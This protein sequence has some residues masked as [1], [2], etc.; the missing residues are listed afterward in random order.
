MKMNPLLES[1]L[2]P[3]IPPYVAT[4]NI[5]PSPSGRPDFFF[6]PMTPELKAEADAIYEAEFAKA[7]DAGAALFEECLIADT[8]DASVFRTLCVTREWIEDE[9]KETNLDAE[10]RASRVALDLE[11]R[12][13]QED[14]LAS[15]PFSTCAESVA[16]KISFAY[17][18]SKT[19]L[20][21][22]RKP[23]FKDADDYIYHENTEIGGVVAR[24][25]AEI[26][27]DQSSTKKPS[28]PL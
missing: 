4:A 13:E 15:P 2:R 14:R 22:T 8:A 26:C 27:Y 18:V 1:I 16:R 21:P 24:K 17:V 25:V 6:L 28:L 5:S 9:L 11:L 23:F 10:Y 19:A 12:Q 3:E 20:G 7:R